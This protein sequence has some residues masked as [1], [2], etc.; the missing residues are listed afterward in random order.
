MNPKELAEQLEGYPLGI[1]VRLK[2][3]VAE[4]WKGII[5]IWE[6]MFLTGLRC[7]WIAGITR[8]TAQ[9]FSICEIPNYG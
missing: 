5:F 1:V 7:S 8:K 3:E 9:R 2:W 4:N 6:Q